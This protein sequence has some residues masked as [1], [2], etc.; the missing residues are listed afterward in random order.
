MNL[1]LLTALTCALV[2][3]PAASAPLT[4][5]AQRAPRTVSA[6]TSTP[7]PSDDGEPEAGAAKPAR[8]KHG[9]PPLAGTLNVNRAT[10]AELRLLPG[11]GKRRAE[12]IVERRDKKPFA[13]VDELGRM[14]GLRNTVHKLR[15]LLAVQ[16]DTTLHPL[17]P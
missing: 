11:I 4:L 5:P 9:K 16:G 7:A 1:A 13:S 8:K 6:P 3:P 2:A 10:E 15:H 17:S 14:K 12:L